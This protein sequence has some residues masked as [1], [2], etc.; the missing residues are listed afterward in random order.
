MMRES[1]VRDMKL[2]AG[3]RMLQT[4]VDDKLQD[5]KNP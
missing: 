5:N 2:V 4:L 1:A 3:I